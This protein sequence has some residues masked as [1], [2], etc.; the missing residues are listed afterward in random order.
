MAE[1]YAS[2]AYFMWR[3]K[4]T[5]CLQLISDAITNETAEYHSSSYVCPSWIDELPDE[6]T[7]M[8]KKEYCKKY[9]SPNVFEEFDPHVT[10]MYNSDEAALKKVPTD[11]YPT[12]TTYSSKVSMTVCG[13]YGTAIRGEEEM[14]AQLHEPI[15]Y[16]F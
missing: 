1:P 12:I 7:R 8:R 15:H 13:D 14:I 6:A 2:G 16:E 4:N 9:G 10:L 5:E 3:I 11:T